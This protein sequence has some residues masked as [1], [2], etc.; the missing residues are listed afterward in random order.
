M[1]AFASGIRVPSTS[2]AEIAKPTAVPRN[3]QWNP[4]TARAAAASS[5]LSSV[6]MVAASCAADSALV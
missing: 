5:G 2:A 1:A 6:S 3:S 4:M